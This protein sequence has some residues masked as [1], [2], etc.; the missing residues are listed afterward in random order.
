[1]IWM[2]TLTA[3]AILIGAS[4]AY[5]I[6][7]RIRDSVG[8]EPQEVAKVIALISQ[9]DLT[10]NVDSCCPNSMMA[11]V[12]VMQ[13]KLKTIVD[14]ITIHL[15]S[16]LPPASVAPWLASTPAR[17]MRKLPTQTLQAA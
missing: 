2:I 4:I 6:S 5:V 14:S 16:C 11:S 9:G 12:S 1:M 8:G 17:P 3:L 13:S 15:M 10:A 7:L